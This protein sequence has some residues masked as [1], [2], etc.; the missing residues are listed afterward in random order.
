M[1]NLAVL[2][3]FVT[4]AIDGIIIINQYGIVST[5]NPSACKLFGYTPEQVVGNNVS[6]LMPQPDRSQHDAYIERYRRTHLPRII[7]IGREVMG[8]RSD[9]T[10]FPFRLGVSEV[11]YDGKS[12]FVGFIHDLTQQKSDEEQL[13]SY[14][15]HL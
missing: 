12:I 6:M 2:S 3:G 14:A 9:G 1:E 4:N 11:I 10:Q 15:S 5:I 7:G 13:K 8:L